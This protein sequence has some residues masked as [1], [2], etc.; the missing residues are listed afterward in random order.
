MLYNGNFSSLLYGCN[1][2]G[3]WIECSNCN[4]R[5]PELLADFLAAEKWNRRTESEVNNDKT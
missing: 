3:Y 2:G 4:I 5:T 1:Q